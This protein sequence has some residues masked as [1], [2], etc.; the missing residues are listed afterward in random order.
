MRISQNRKCVLAAILIAGV[1]AL[2][3][4]AAATCEKSPVI[5]LPNEMKWS[6]DPQSHGLQTALLFGDSTAA[7]PYAE[8]IRIPAHSRLK[9]HFHSDAVRMVTVLSGTL[10]FAF[11]EKF[12]ET[13][14]KTLTVGAFFVEPNGESH[15][16]L[17]KDEDV[18]LQLDAIGPA[19]TTY[20]KQAE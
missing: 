1:A 12:D 3:V 18:V 19:G 17:T 15:Y 11:G 6:G 9:P 14:L 4:G 20:V 13:K 5:L 2:S 10:Y 16:S 8:R 7:R